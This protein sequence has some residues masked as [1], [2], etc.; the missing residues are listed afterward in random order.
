MAPAASLDR[1]CGR[2]CCWVVL[3]DPCSTP[4]AGGIAIVTL[5]CSFYRSGNRGSGGGGSPSK[6]Q[7]SWLTE[8]LHSLTAGSGGMPGGVSGLR[9]F[10]KA[11]VVLPTLPHSLRVGCLFP[12]LPRDWLFSIPSLLVKST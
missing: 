6:G 12:Q 1:H 5:L 2:W 10:R 9:L 3:L 8:K 11:T 4:A 7:W